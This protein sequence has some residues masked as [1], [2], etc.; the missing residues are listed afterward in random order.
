MN[1]QE[2][3]SA[4]RFWS[5]FYVPKFERL[6]QENGT[7]TAA[8]VGKY[9]DFLRTLMPLL[10]PAPGHGQP[11]TSAQITHKGMPLEFSMNLTDRKPPNVRF[12][13]EPL[14][15]RYDDIGAME[16]QYQRGRQLLLNTHLCE[17]LDT[18]WLDQLDESLTVKGN[19]RSCRTSVVHMLHLSPP[20]RGFLG[21][22]LGSE[23]NGAKTVAKAYWAPVAL[24]IMALPEDMLRPPMKGAVLGT[25][26]PTGAAKK[27]ALFE[28]IFNASR[29]AVLKAARNLDPGLH[30]ALESLEHYLQRAPAVEGMFVAID[31]IPAR[32]GAR[33]KLYFRC[34]SNAFSSV[35]DAMTFGGQALD[36][37]TTQGVETLRS[38]WHLLRCDSLPLNDEN[39]H[40][41]V[42]EPGHRMNALGF[43][44][45][46][47]AGR[48]RPDFKLYIPIWQFHKND[49]SVVQMV[50]KLCEDR[51]WGFGHGKYEALLKRVL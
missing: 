34:R 17:S 22:D 16:S 20:P 40:K 31:C 38:L 26:E 18:T 14:A 1:N 23:E 6:L 49:A 13:F 3:S 15:D 27:K 41:E 10:G 19:E 36:D 4:V 21:M 12:A 28:A 46:L 47:R 45:E 25:G 8:E 24:G 2:D 9:V 35:R 7:Y 39:H 44:Y 11:P 5:N 42:L 50:E 33:L 29:K 43:S 37:E 32:D 51:G 30:A 48:S